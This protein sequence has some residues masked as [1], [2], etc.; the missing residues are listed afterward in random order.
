MV[1][2]GMIT[3]SCDHRAA[4][5]LSHIIPRI[6]IKKW[7]VFLLAEF[8]AWFAHRDKKSFQMDAGMVL[9]CIPAKERGGFKS[10]IELMFAMH[11]DWLIKHFA[12]KQQTN[13]PLC[14]LCSRAI[15][16]RKIVLR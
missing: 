12:V 7:Q 16:K 10:L 5:E 8:D 9:A 2:G 6:S 14:Y 11:A 15:E 1:D 4:Q 13:P 3:I